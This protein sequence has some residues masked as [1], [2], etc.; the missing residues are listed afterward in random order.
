MRVEATDALDD[1]LRASRECRQVQNP[2]F[3]LSWLRGVG[4][5]GVA[6][7]AIRRTAFDCHSPKGSS[8]MPG[9]AR[10]RR[11]CGSEAGALSTELRGHLVS[12]GYDS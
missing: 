6:T 5:A 7:A 2:L 12:H 1:M 4:V 8:C 11:P 10:R 9:W 3:I